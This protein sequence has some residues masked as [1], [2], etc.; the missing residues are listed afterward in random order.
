MINWV[1]FM[2][3]Q[4]RRQDEIY[5][6]KQYRLWRTLAKQNPGAERQYHRWLA[7]L[8]AQLSTWGCQLQVRF[9]AEG[10]IE[11]CAA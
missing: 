3:E 4:Q 11:P 5:Q 8:G 10:S 9:A 1:E 7:R 6:A 2:V